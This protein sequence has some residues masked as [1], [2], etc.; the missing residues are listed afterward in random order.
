MEKSHKQELFFKIS[1]PYSNKRATLGF[2][3]LD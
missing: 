3:K 2:P 1:F